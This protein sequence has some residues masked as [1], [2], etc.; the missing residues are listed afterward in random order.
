MTYRQASWVK[1]Y[2]FACIFCAIIG[3]AMLFSEPSSM[4][5]NRRSLSDLWSHGVGIMLSYLGRCIRVVRW[6]CV[7]GVDASVVVAGWWKWEDGG[8]IESD[9][10]L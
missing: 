9:T 8:E 10:I 1:V 3:Q 4:M 2:P 7:V 6:S 5:A